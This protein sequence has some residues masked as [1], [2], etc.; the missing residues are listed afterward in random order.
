VLATMKQIDD[1]LPVVLPVSLQAVPNLKA[2][3]QVV[4]R[5][6]VASCVI[7]QHAVWPTF[8][9]VGAPIV[10]LPVSV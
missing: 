3:F 9:F 6:P 1:T 8:P 7:V 2:A 5:P 4:V 10:T